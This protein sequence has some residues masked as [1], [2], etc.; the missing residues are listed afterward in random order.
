MNF[1]QHQKI[2]ENYFK[3]I[4]ESNHQLLEL[5][6][7]LKIQKNQYFPIYGFSKIQKYLQTEY[8][9]KE[10]QKEKI[11]NLVTSHNNVEND[12]DSI[13]EIIIDDSISQSNKNL[14]IIFGIMNDHINL[15]SIEEYLRNYPDKKTTDYRKILCVYDY[16]KYAE[17][18]AAI[19]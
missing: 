8:D 19:I 14:A 7:K 13:V 1:I 3:I 6:D 2:M 4:D 15:D 9:L 12:H 16:K 10:S 17:E 11:F 5:I 18:S